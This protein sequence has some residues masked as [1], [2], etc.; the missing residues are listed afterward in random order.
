MPQKIKRNKKPVSK[1]DLKKA[2]DEALQDKEDD[3]KKNIK[4]GV[5]KP[6]EVVKF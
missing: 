3:S 6:G 4:K 1:D 2:L 5:I